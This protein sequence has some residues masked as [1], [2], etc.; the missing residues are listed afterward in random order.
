VLL[1]LFEFVREKVCCDFGVLVP[2][3]VVY[4]LIWLF[5]AFVELLELWMPS[6]LFMK[7]GCLCLSYRT[8]KWVRKY[9]SARD[10]SWH[11]SAGPLWA[12][13]KVADYCDSSS[14][15]TLTCVKSL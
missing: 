7:F 3:F 5:V 6:L 4:E 2:S 10:M 8:L 13:V 9:W 14:T 11:E 1:Y 15:G 12:C